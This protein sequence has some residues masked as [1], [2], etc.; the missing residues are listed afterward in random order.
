MYLENSSGATDD[1]LPTCSWKPLP[2]APAVISE[3]EGFYLQFCC[4][5]VPLASEAAADHAEIKCVEYS[6]KFGM[7]VD[8]LCSIAIYYCV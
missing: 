8:Q 6:S 5:C 7:L 3:G 2:K 1:P 4:Q